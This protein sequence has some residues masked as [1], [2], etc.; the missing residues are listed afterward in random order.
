MLFAAT[1]TPHEQRFDYHE[2]AL[3]DGQP[4]RLYP[5]SMRYCWPKEIDLMAEDAGL[6]MDQ[7]WENW[8]RRLY[9]EDSPKHVTVYRPRRV[10][11]KSDPV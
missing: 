3:V 11:I 6:M 8:D 7:R 5:G 4:P 10:G 1:N 2:V 9:T